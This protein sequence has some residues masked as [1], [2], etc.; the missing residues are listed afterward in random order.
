V[1]GVVAGAWLGRTPAPPAPTDTA[2]DRVSIVAPEGTSITRGEAPQVSPDGRQVAFVGAGASGRNVIHVRRLDSL[3]WRTLPG[4]EDASLIFWA[5]DSQRLGF[6]AAGQLRTTSLSGGTPQGIAPAPVARGGSW[7]RQDRIIFQGFPSDPLRV[8]AAS[9]G[10]ATALPLPKGTLGSRWFPVF[11]PDGRHYLYLTSRQDERV[12][13]AIH[14]GSIDAPESRELVRS[15]AS[16]AYADPGYLLFRRGTALM[17]QRFDPETRELRDAAYQVADDVGFNAIT[18]Q[19]LFSASS[20]GTLVYQGSAPGSQLAWFDRHGN[21]VTIVGP[22]GDYGG[23]CLTAGDE[24]VVYDLSDPASGMVDIWAGDASGG[25]P[26]RLTF[27][28]AVDFYPVCSPTGQEVVF[29]SLREGPPNLFRLAAGAPG[30]E[31]ALLRSPRPK[32]ASDWSRDGRWLVYSEFNRETSFDIRVLP[33]SGGDPVLFAGTAADERN[34][35]LSPDVRWMAYQSNET[36][37]S[38]VY[39][40]PFPTTGARWQ[41]SRGGGSQPQWRRDGGELFYIAQDKRLMAVAITA[42][43]GRL[44]AGQPTALFQ[45]RATQRDPA[46][47]NRQYAVSSDGTRFLV[48]TTTDNPLPITMVRNW[49]ALLER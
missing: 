37:T 43:A 15:A 49:R 33:L 4:T 5:P 41:I 9:G 42:R 12:G 26:S 20:G 1:L 45:T 11:L 13:Y 46:N 23:L 44:A 28:R 29:A 17:A 47:L 39:V 19:G 30:S 35:T 21:R 27:Q 40:Q 16:V 25:A 48:A 10:E 38:E 18:Y 14:V 2:V 31:V 3:E 34:G 8:V 36:G 24:R 7:S 32:L 6:F 22:P